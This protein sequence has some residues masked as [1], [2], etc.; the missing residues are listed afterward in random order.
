MSKNTPRHIKS[1]VQDFHDLGLIGPNGP[2]GPSGPNPQR[3]VHFG[4][5]DSNGDQQELIVHD[6]DH[7]YLEIRDL[8]TNGNQ[9][10]VLN[11]ANALDMVR[12]LNEM[13]ALDLMADL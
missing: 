3:V 8:T 1:I 7:Y 11:K 6:D 12:K 13:F 10:F 5:K 2:T 4:A 9:R